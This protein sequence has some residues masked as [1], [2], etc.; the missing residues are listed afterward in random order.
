[1]DSFFV[2]S[3]LKKRVAQTVQLRAEALDYGCFINEVRLRKI[4]NLSE[5]Q[6]KTKTNDTPLVVDFW[7]PWCGPCR[8]TKPILEKLR[9][10]YTG[11]VDVLFVN[12]DESKDVIQ[13]YKIMGIPTMMAFRDGKL[14]VRKTGA[15]TE[16][17]Y[18]AIF[19][20]LNSGQE[21]AVPLEPFE[22]LV[23]LGGGTAVM[24]FGLDHGVWWLVA[25]GAVVAFLGIYD[26]CPLWAA[27][28][29]LFKKKSA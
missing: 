17:G 14:A 16:V 13:H 20:A 18:R 12:A 29:G 15:Q 27:I 7:A 11:K 22:R 8:A 5:F 21:I 25:I 2:K 23:R 1:L 4:M 28:T 19:D 24:L 3:P 26:R 6:E 10:E 9:N